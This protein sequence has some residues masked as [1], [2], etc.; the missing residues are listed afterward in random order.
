MNEGLTICSVVYNDNESKLFDL[1]MR[2]ILKYTYPEPQII[3]C[4]HGNSDILD[5]YRHLPNV[6]I[7]SNTPKLKGGSNAHGE[8]LNLILPLVKTKRAAVVESDCVV[9]SKDWYRLDTK[10]KLS[11]AIKPTKDGTMHYYI[12]AMVF[13]TQI[14]KGMDW[15][16]GRDGTRAHN[17]SYV[18]EDC[19]WRIRD[20]VAP[21]EVQ[22][23]KQV[24][25]KT[26]DGQH[27]DGRFCSDEFWA[28]GKAIVAHYGRGSHMHGKAIRKGFLPHKE[29]LKLFKDV[30]Y[31]LLH[32]T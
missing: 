26:G 19:A 31:Q 11:A 5:K 9:L 17:K 22:L 16:P 27:F 8:G 24:D 29:Q 12:C 23:M 25:T 18:I 32:D 21:S 6:K 30:C 15:R 3:I 7:I 20:R 14:L 10:Y 28:F 4:D 13:D 2:S 1:T